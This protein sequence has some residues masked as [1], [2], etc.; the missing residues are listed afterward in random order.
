M[1]KQT[2]RIRRVVT[3]LETVVA[4]GPS[5]P[6]TSPSAVY[7]VLAPLIGSEAKEIFVALLLNGQHRIN[8]YLEVS[9]G[10]LTASLVHPREVFGPALS[11]GA[12]AL[13]VAHNHPSG[14]PKPS[15][16]DIAVT[17]RLIEAGNLLGVSVLD[18]IVIGDQRYHSI[19]ES[20]PGLF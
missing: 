11:Q 13:I 15:P 9:V 3:R 6:A 17:K 4:E 19:R 1:D 20:N 10:T 7:D 16:E 14:D 18:H 8:G 12:A 5:G 2:N